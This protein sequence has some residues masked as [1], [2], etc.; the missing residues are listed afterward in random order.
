M[1]YVSIDVDMNDILSELSSR[2]KQNLADELYD[3]GYYQSELEK[4]FK[5]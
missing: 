4:D 3:D 2:E 1:T 5:K